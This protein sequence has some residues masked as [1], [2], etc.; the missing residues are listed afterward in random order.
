MAGIVGVWWTVT[1]NASGSFWQLTLNSSH[2][3]L[4]LLWCEQSSFSYSGGGGGGGVGGVVCRYKNYNEE[5][6]W[7]R[8]VTNTTLLPNW[9][10]HVWPRI[11]LLRIGRLIRGC[12]DR[13]SWW[14]FKLIWPKFTKMECDY[15]LDCKN[16]LTCKIS[17]NM[18]EEEEY[19]QR[20]LNGNWASVAYAIRNVTRTFYCTDLAQ[21]M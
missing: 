1:V 5:R 20:L 3:T 15:L 13:S 18:K 10:L 16:G 9:I 17:S 4:L 21:A 11:G 12:R 14:E 8:G 19:D 6:T 7:M 2:F